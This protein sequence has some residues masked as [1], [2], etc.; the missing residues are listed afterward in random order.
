MK[1][2]KV[3]LGKKD[4]DVQFTEFLA[5]QNCTSAKKFLGP[6]VPTT[7]NKYNKIIIAQFK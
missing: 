6:P 3:N 4:L 1:G 2:P 7:P 5:F